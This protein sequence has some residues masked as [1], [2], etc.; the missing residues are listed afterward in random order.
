MTL[1]HIH[2]CQSYIVNQ[3]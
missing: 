2:A 3:L 1:S